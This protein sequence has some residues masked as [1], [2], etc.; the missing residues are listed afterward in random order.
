ME[1]VNGAIESKLSEVHWGFVKNPVYM[2]AHIFIGSTRK[3]R[4]VKFHIAFKVQSNTIRLDKDQLRNHG[5][6]EAPKHT[7]D[8][9]SRLPRQSSILPSS[10]S[11]PLPS[12]AQY[13]AP[14]PVRKTLSNHG[15]IWST[16]TN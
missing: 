15:E 13:N 14:Q 6:V 10:R 9:L 8:W 5:V 12:V 2:N 1:E 16:C 7:P 11:A 3:D 4:G